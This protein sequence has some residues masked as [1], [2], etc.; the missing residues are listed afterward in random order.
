MLP[1]VAIFRARPILATSAMVS[2]VSLEKFCC[3]IVPLVSIM[4]D[5]YHG[6]WT[7]T[8]MLTRRH[9]GGNIGREIA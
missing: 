9:I 7:D 4:S 2:Q 8:G 1:V 3:K 5:L 6:G